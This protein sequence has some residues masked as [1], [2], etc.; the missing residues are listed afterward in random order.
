MKIAIVTGATGYIGSCIVREFLKRDYIVGC[1]CRNQEKFTKTF[2]E[3]NAILINVD[4]TNYDQLMESID[5]FCRVYGMI[6][7]LVNCAGG[8]A[9]KREKGFRWQSREVFDEIIGVNLLGTIYTTHVCMKYLVNGCV[10]NIGSYLG[11][12][13]MAKSSEYS[14][15]KGGVIALTKALAK[16]CSAAGIR[17]N[18]ISPGYVPRPEEILE[19]G[20]RVCSGFTYIGNSVTPQDIANSV[21]FLSSDKSYYIT[22]QNIVIDGG[23]SLTLKNISEETCKITYEYFDKLDEFSY[24]IYGTGKEARS[25]VDILREKEKYEKIIFFVDSDRSKWGG[26]FCGKEVREPFCLQE[27]SDLKVIIAVG[28]E[29]EKEINA[30]LRLLGVD[31][32]NIISYKKTSY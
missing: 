32:E 22:G 21:V 15:A 7:V 18:C 26:E 10:I 27:R 3:K 28:T 25:Y 29:Y 5:S 2:K 17:V 14:A 20:E 19:H 8:S 12:N 6:D 9:R 1:V 4:V 24:V 11:V 30:I 31:E 13:G 16:E 23:A